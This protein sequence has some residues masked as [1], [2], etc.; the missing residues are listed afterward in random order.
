MFRFRPFPTEWPPLNLGNLTEFHRYRPDD[1]PDPETGE[2]KPN[3][4]DPW[5]SLVYFLTV[6]AGVLTYTEILDMYPHEVLD[7]FA[8]AQ[9]VKERERIE[10]DRARIEAELEAKRRMP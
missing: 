9:D 1:D 4:D 7:M 10:E 8:Y 6:T 5:L 3:F 2:K